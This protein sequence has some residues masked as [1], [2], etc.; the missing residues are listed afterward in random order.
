[1]NIYIWF[2]V[3]L[4][5]TFVFSC[6]SF[7]YSIIY[8]YQCGLIV[9]RIGYMVGSG[10]VHMVT[11]GAG[12]GINSTWI[13]CTNSKEGPVPSEGTGLLISKDGR[14][15]AGQVK[16]QVSSQRSFIGKNSQ[17]VHDTVEGHNLGLLESPKDNLCQTL[18][19]HR[20]MDSR[21]QESEAKNMCVVTLNW[22]LKQFFY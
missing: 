8:L 22:W 16:Q 3:L 21:H 9:G 19:K 2:G 14:T 15:H 7:I 4:Y 17:N 6:Y 1:M 13:K 11:F 18:E 12:S 20:N 10:L 5:G